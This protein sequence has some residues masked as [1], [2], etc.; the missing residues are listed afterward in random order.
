MTT[1]YVQDFSCLLIS[2]VRE[3][4]PNQD[5]ERVIFW[6]IISFLSTKGP[7]NRG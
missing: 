2:I 3:D 5:S 1:C 4:D 6:D 7:M